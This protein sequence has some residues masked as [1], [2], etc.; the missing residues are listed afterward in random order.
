MTVRVSD[1]GH[2]IP[3]QELPHIFERFYRLEKSR[4]D[5]PG[6]AGL[7][8]S[9]AK[10]ILELH[11]TTIKAFSRLNAGTTFVFELPLAKPT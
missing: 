8:L 7:G 3:E 2:G 10:R 9:I 11:G 5:S 1:T 6:G 4:G